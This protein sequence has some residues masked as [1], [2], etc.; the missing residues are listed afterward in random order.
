MHSIFKYLF[1]FETYSIIASDI[2]FTG[3]DINAQ[4]YHGFSPLHLAARKGHLDLV[5]WL[6]IHGADPYKQTKCGMRP[7]DM[8]REEG[9][10]LIIVSLLNILSMRI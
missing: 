9:R 1:N 4:N 6:M 10:I 2:S 8:A 5:R 3:C 7:I